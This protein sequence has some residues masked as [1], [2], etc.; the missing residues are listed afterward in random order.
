MLFLSA[1]ILVLTVGSSTFIYFQGLRS[2]RAQVKAQ[3]TRIYVEATQASQPPGTPQNPGAQKPKLVPEQEIPN[4]LKPMEEWA[5]KGAVA[6]AAGGAGLTLAAV[7]AVTSLRRR[8]ERR[9]T[10]NA[11]EWEKTIRRIDET[12]TLLQTQT[13]ARQP[14]ESE[15]SK[16]QRDSDRRVEERTAT[17]SKTY[18]DL[19]VELNSRKQA[20][21]AL[22]QQAR[23]L[24][25]SKDVL[26]LHVQ[27]RT[28][29][30]Q[31]LQR[32][33]EHILNSAGEGIY[34]LD[35]QGRTTFVN[36]AA[37]KLTGWKVEELIGKSEEEVFHHPPPDGSNI[38]QTAL[39]TRNGE[40]FGDQV[41]FR[42]DGASFAV[43]YVRTPILEKDKVVGAVVIFKDITER[44]R[45]EETLARKAAELTRS[46]A[47]LEQL[48][49]VASHDLQEPLRKFQA[50]GDRLKSKCD[51]AKLEDE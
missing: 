11:Q 37:A 18:T 39:L 9:V 28:Q 7:L 32:R 46:N 2:V 30:L 21:K 8:L 48:A 49:Y 15:L 29:E 13:L 25:R 19:E 24:G 5:L 41:F 20:E 10:V 26:E 44:K 33:Y 38:S 17:L 43:E 45:T 4:L 31:K 6:T 36:P 35:L 16:L 50:F 51:P 27:A 40:H 22:S 3:G 23:E 34:G 47:E 1:A 42:K 14:W 12:S